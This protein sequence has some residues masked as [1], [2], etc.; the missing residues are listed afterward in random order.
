MSVDLSQVEAIADL[1]MRLA[2]R[3]GHGNYDEYRWEGLG[4][5]VTFGYGERADHPDLYRIEMHGRE[6]FSAALSFVPT[7]WYQVSVTPGAWIERFLMINAPQMHFG[8]A[9]FAVCVPH[10]D[11]ER[12]SKGMAPVTPG[13]AMTAAKRLAACSWPGSPE[14]D[15]L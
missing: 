11:C 4:F 5:S 9:D 3:L 14:A 8:T 6:V 13:E 2:I 7:D 12:P 10:I 1:V 15:K